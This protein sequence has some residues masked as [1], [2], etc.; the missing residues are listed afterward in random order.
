MNALFSPITFNKVT[1]KNRIVMSPMCMYSAEDDGLVAP[2]HLAHYESRAA[3]QAGMVM[4]EAT[5]VLP[6]GRISHNDLGIWSDDH[7]NGLQQIN[8]GIHRH[9]ARSAVQLAHAGRKA[10]LEN[11]IFAPSSLPF[12][13]DYKTPTEMSKDDINRAIEAFAEGARRAKAAHFDVIELHGAHG[14]LINQFLSPL[15]NKR[16]DEYGGNPENRFRFLEEIIT[17]VHETWDGPI[18]VRISADEYDEAGNTMDDFIYFSRKMKELGVDLIDCSTGGVVPV[19]PEAYP[20]YQVRHAE[21]IR[22][23]ASIQTGAVGLITTGI[24]AEE[25]VRNERADLVFIARAMLRNP[26]WAKAAAD[27]LGY[28]LEA[29]RQYARGW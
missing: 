20:G 5:A 24:Q 15:T 9:G 10:N 2:F 14:Y 17:R 28:S 23:E 7:I 1:L 13:E 27:E 6:E 4:I 16:N 18:F 8:E 26:Y 25:I 12:N 29:P 11:E 22:Q 21:T 3:G 19:R